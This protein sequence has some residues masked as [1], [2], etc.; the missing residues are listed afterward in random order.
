[1]RK[2]E[3]GMYTRFSPLDLTCK[4]IHPPPP[5]PPPTIYHTPWQNP[6]QSG[7][8]IFMQPIY[9]SPSFLPFPGHPLLLAFKLDSKH[10]KQQKH[11]RNWELIVSLS[12]PHTL[13]LPLYM[14]FGCQ[15]GHTQNSIVFG[16]RLATPS[17]FTPQA[18]FIICFVVFI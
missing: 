9:G 17:L 13:P 16:D 6:C 18:S 11:G 12:L 1:M 3:N 14:I 5:F 4:G 8:I 10:G 7:R 15:G 2:T